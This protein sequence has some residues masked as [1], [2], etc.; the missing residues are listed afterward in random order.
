ML[1]RK[2]TTDLPPKATTKQRSWDRKEVKQNVLDDDS[3]CTSL[4]YTVDSLEEYDAM[5]IILKNLYHPA[6]SSENNQRFLAC[7]RRFIL[8]QDVVSESKLRDL[9]IDTP[10]KYRQLYKKFIIPKKRREMLELLRDYF[11]RSM[12]AEKNANATVFPRPESIDNPEEI[13]EEYKTAFTLSAENKDN[14]NVIFPGFR[15]DAAEDPDLTLEF[16]SPLI[17]YDGRHSFP[18]SL[19]MEL[20]T[21]EELLA[22]YNEEDEVRE[23]FERWIESSFS[24]PMFTIT[25]DRFGDVVFR[26]LGVED[27]LDVWSQQSINQLKDLVNRI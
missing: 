24:L 5:I 10:Y 11:L 14:L 13:P 19:W 20:H 9:K 12:A 8:E 26:S 17:E 7:L 25:L 4:I 2:A 21:A 16:Y 6:Q 15:E 1:K 23:L 27:G 18:S 22:V 3:I